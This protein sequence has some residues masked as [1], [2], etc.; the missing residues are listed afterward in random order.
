MQDLISR[1]GSQNVQD[2]QQETVANQTHLKSRVDKEQATF[3]VQQNQISRPAYQKFPG[4]QKKAIWQNS[5]V[6]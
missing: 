2:Y 3:S 6:K 4:R 5:S 1:A